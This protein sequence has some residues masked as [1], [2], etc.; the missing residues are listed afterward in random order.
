[1]FVYNPRFFR[2]LFVGGVS[3]F[4]G[5]TLMLLSYRSALAANINQG[6][7][8]SMI[9]ITSISVTIAAY[10]VFRER[11][12]G[13]QFFGIILIVSAFTLIVFYQPEN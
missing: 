6:I 5:S 9:S 8:T 13:I 10:A 1:M 2:I 11:V 7:C 12:S 4:L 3:E